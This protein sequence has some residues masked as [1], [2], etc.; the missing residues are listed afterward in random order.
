[1]VDAATQPVS[2]SRARECEESARFWTTAIGPY[3][4]RMR[5]RADNYAIT[6]ALLSTLTGL[7][8]WSTLAAS[9]RWPA[10]LA[11]SIVALIAAAVTVIPQ[12]KG[13]AACAEAAAALGPRYGHVLGELIDALEMLDRGHPDG[14]Y[15]VRQAVKEFEEVRTD[16]QALKPYPADL[17]KEIDERRAA[18]KLK[19]VGAH[20]D[21]RGQPPVKD[22]GNR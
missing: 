15:C 13:Y 17:Q 21:Q 18:N 16:K 12:I 11:V 4:H 8:V 1:M 7:G 10:V 9:T 3:A 5:K 2:E 14:P 19:N 20:E 22:P 6:A